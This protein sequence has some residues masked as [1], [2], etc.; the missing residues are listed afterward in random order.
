MSDLAAP[1][2]DRP[3]ADPRS[4]SVMSAEE[5]RKSH[6]ILSAFKDAWTVW[7]ALLGGLAAWIIHLLAFAALSDLST[8]S[9]SV[10]WAMHGITA[11]TLA[12][13]AVAIVLSVRLTRDA[14]DALRERARR[15]GSGPLPRARRHPDR[16]HQ[17]RPHRP[18]RAVPQ[19]HPQERRCLT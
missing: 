16:R 10:R 8:R 19:H 3:A 11:A 13:T 5:A 7:Y 12:M 9:A 15:S 1:A 6:S 14:G 4:P 18:R 17:P 2:T